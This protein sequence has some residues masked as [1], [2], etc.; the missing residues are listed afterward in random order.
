[1]VR[2]YLEYNLR[3]MWKR[4]SFQFVFWGLL[5]LGIGM[6]FYYVIKYWGYYEYALPSADS[7]YI[8]NGDS[9]QWNYIMA[10]FPF[11]ITLP[12]GF[13]YLD[14]KKAGVNLY[15]QTRGNRKGYFY[16]QLLACFIGSAMVFFVPFLINVMLNGILFPITGNSYIAT[17]YAYDWN[18]S[19][20]ITGAG[21]GNGWFLKSVAI[22]HP[23]VYNFIYVC[24]IGIAAGIMGMLVY[25]ISILVQRNRISVLVINFLLF[26][27]YHVLGNL[28]EETIKI[29]KFCVY[30]DF[31]GYMCNGFFQEGRKYSIF[32][33][34]LVIEVVVS[35]IVVRRCC[36]GNEE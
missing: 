10:L 2:T 24:I 15:L 26:Q 36:K 7:L 19:A 13:S 27:V 34:F 20:A 29:D 17:R 8:G 16:G 23:Q 31:V 9:M 18:W 25:A 1:M 28:S 6:P 32:F 3:L 11:L 14:E 30:L 4:K 5:L 35:I 22:A 12:F 21:T 33:A